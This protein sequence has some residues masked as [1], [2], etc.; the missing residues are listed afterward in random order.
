MD[1]GSGFEALSRVEMAT[2]PAASEQVNIPATGT[3]AIEVDGSGNVSIPGTIQ[4]G[5]SIPIDGTAN[6]I[7]SSGDLELQTG[8]TS[9]LVI[10]NSTGNVGI[11][12]TTPATELDVDGV[13]TA[14]ETNLINVVPTL[15]FSASGTPRTSHIDAGFSAAKLENQAIRFNVSD[16]TPTETTEVMQLRGDGRVGIG[17]ST[18]A[19]ELDVVGTVTGHVVRRRR[20]GLDG[21]QLGR[22]VLRLERRLARR[23]RL[24]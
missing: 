18:P 12:T 20:L 6:T 15:R 23:R 10:Q 14:K 7:I 19:T 1:D 3:P 2:A 11:G 16:N 4:A 22:P 5:S 13:V 17:T 21:D 24:R 8:G 9:R